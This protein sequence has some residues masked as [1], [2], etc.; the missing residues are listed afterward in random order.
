M[1]LAE[2]T[3]QV[4]IEFFILVSRRTLADIDSTVLLA[5]STTPMKNLLAVVD[6]NEQFLRGVIAIGFLIISDQYQ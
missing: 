2:C 3:L 6:T 5:V 4:Q 1:R